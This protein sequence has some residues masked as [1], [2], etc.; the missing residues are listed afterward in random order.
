MRRQ[1]SELCQQP[2]YA[3]NWISLMLANEGLR[4]EHMARILGI[5]Q[6][7]VS[8]M[9]IDL[10][11]QGTRDGSIAKQRHKTEKNYVFTTN[12]TTECKLLRV[13]RNKSEIQSLLDMIYI[14]K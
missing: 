8:C 2:G 7:T 10:R 12:Y 14:I 5:H 9:V 3:R 6:L 4:Q 1:P 13:K 11:K